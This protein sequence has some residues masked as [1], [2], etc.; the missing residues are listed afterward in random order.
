MRSV[1]LLT[2][3]PWTRVLCLGLNHV[4]RK[5]SRPLDDH[6]NKLLTVPGGSDG[7][8]GVIV[9][10]PDYLTYR[11]MGEADVN[12]R[13]RLPRREVRPSCPCAV[14]ALSVRCPG[15]PVGRWHRLGGVVRAGWCGTGWVVLSALGGVAQAGWCGPPGYL[16]PTGLYAA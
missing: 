8:G 11:K 13:L 4:V 2:V 3:V 6:A 10:S 7:P 5:E 16:A 1:L 9:C 14:R 12:I 15:A